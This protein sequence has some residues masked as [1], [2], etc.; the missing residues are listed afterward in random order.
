MK[1]LLDETG[2]PAE[3]LEIEITESVLMQNLEAARQAIQRIRS[4]GIGISI[5][6]FG[7]G[8]AS[9]EYLRHLPVTGLKIDRVFVADLETD[10]KAKKLMACMIDVGRALDL[11]V[12]AEGVETPGQC[13]V[14]R[15]M[16][17][18]QAQGFLFSA[19]MP[20]DTY[21]QWVSQRQSV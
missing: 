12:T 13:D 8:Y 6:D 17:C 4:F 21:H 10:E 19:A 2:L 1:A 18:D 7:T 5:D 14:L 3:R 16:G 11:E 9:F 20:A 15:S